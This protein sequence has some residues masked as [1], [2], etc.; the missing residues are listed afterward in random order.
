MKT[1]CLFLILLLE[2]GP[3]FAVD[4]TVRSTKTRMDFVRHTA[5]PATGLNKL[6]CIGFIMDHRKPLDCGG[7]DVPD[8]LQWLT[9][10]AWKA[11]SKWERS[12]PACEFQTKGV[13]PLGAIPWWVS[14]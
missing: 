12:N 2:I 6:P 9:V 1:L 3:A 4:K 13:P 14:Q 8:N 7:P 5:C 10:E 11:K